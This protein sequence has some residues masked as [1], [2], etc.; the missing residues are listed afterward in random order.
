LSAP[1]YSPIGVRFPA[2]MTMSF[3]SPPKTIDCISYLLTSWLM[4]D[5]LSALQ[6]RVLVCDGAMGTMLYSRGIFI[7]RCFDELNVSNADLVRDVHL[8]YIKAG[9]DIVETNTFGGNRTKLMTHGLADRTRDIN[10][11]GARIAREAA[12]N[13][14]YVA[15]AIGPLGIRIEPWGKTSIDEARGIFREQAKAL[16]DGEVD[17]FILETFSDLNEIYA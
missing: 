13:S 5:F 12:G 7:S 3:M 10:L 14:V 17:L 15:G 16:L 9:V 2:T 1:P 4:L 6:E 11:H 8:D